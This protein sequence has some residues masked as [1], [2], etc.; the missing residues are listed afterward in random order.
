MTNQLF[1][2]EKSPTCRSEAAEST[3]HALS[4]LK[5]TKHTVSVLIIKKTTLNS[6]MQRPAKSNSGNNTS[7]A[8]PR[9]RHCKYRNNHQ[10]PE[11]APGSNTS[12]LMIA[13]DRLPAD[14][15]IECDAPLERA[16]RGS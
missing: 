5:L 9:N 14:S 6:R 12:L 13:I 15:G 1:H 16:N 4:K 2:S 11:I 10:Q 3:Q 8:K 7:H